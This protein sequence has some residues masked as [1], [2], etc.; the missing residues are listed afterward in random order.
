MPRLR[1]ECIIK[2][3]ASLRDPLLALTCRCF[4]REGRR[5]GLKLKFVLTSGDSW[6]DPGNFKTGRVDSELTPLE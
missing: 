5:L 2:G 3:S 1:R 6:S 4:R